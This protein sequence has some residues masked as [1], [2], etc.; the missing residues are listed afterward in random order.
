M[1]YSF[2]STST[3]ADQVLQAVMMQARG[4]KSGCTHSTLYTIIRKHN[5]L[6]FHIPT[7]AI[8]RKINSKLTLRITHV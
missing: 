4:K 8:Q 3:V 5:L 6:G 2:T 7:L 1:F